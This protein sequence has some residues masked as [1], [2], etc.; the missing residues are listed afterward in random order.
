MAADPLSSATAFPFSSP[1]SRGFLAQKVRFRREQALGRMSQRTRDK[2]RGA[3][4]GCGRGGQQL[5][6][7]DLLQQHIIDSVTVACTQRALHTPSAARLQQGGDGTGQPRSVAKPA[8]LSPF[9]ALTFELSA[10]SIA[11]PPP[12]MP[13]EPS[14]LHL[15]K[16]TKRTK[17]G[18]LILLL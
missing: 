11:L 13:V 6:G 15:I 9:A 5:A 8:K 1:G 2:G 4:K 14:S 16:V 18:P 17:E 3:R 12:Y 10:L 7:A